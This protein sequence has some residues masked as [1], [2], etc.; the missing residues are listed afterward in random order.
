MSAVV[1][2][3]VRR[4]T[5]PAVAASLMKEELCLALAAVAQ[6]R[7]SLSTATGG[8]TSASPLSTETLARRSLRLLPRCT[9]QEVRMIANGAHAL[10]WFSSPSLLVTEA[11]ARTLYRHTVNAG[12]SAI[13]AKSAA[14]HKVR[15]GD[16]LAVV[17]LASEAQRYFDA[18][19]FLLATQ[20]AV[21]VGAQST[22]MSAA[23]A[24]EFV[25]VICGYAGEADGAA[26]VERLAALL[27][28]SPTFASNSPGLAVLKACMRDRP[29]KVADK[30]AVSY[31]RWAQRRRS[32]LEHVRTTGDAAAPTDAA[33]GVARTPIQLLK[34]RYDAWQVVLALLAEEEEVSDHRLQRA[35]EAAGVCHIQDP[36]TLSTLDRTVALRVASS[37]LPNAVLISYE[38]RVYAQ[39]HYYPQALAALKQRDADT[40]SAVA[41]ASAV[42]S[43][44]SQPTAEALQRV[45]VIRRVYKDT[46][47]G[48]V[49][50]EKDLFQITT[51]ID[52]SSADEVAM[53]ACVFAR[54]KEVPTS[55]LILLPRQLMSLTVEGVVALV[56]A[57]RHDRRGALS[58]VLQECLRTSAHLQECILSAPTELLVELAEALSRPVSRWTS[59]SDEM[60][61]L[62]EQVVDMVIA[63]VLPQAEQMPLSTLLLVMTIGGFHLAR[64]DDLVQAVCNRLADHL[65]AAVTPPSII[66][67]VE[68][69]A[70]LHSG[71]S[72]QE[73]LLDVL[74]DATAAH[75]SPL[76]ESTISADASCLAGLVRFATTQ[77][78]YG[79]P[80]MAAVG[81][82]L[83]QRVRQG[84]W[85]ALP[86]EML[87][88]AALFALDS[89]ALISSTA[90]LELPHA[91]VVH[92]VEAQRLPSMMTVDLAIALVQLMELMPT[93]DAENAQAL[94]SHV[95]RVA[96]GLSPVEVARLLALRHRSSTAAAT[97]SVEVE[98]VHY[99]TVSRHV[100]ALPPDTFTSL[101]LVA[102]QPAFDTVLAN[103]LVD[104]LP[105][106]AD[107]LSAHQ[108]SQCVF[109]LG[110]M[111]DAGQRLSH[112]VMTE[113]LSDYVVDNIE[114]F[115]SGR[116]IAALLHGF[117]KLQCTKRNLYSVFS[118]Q[119]LRR[120]IIATLE[121]R[122]ISLLFFAFGSARFVNKDLM[123]IL[124]RTFVVHVDSLAAP[125]VLMSLRGLSRMNLLN[126]TFYRKVGRRA[127]EL[128]DE[129]PLQAQC[130][131][132]HAYGAVEEAHPKLAATLSKRI[133]AAVESLPSVSVAT[134]V[135]TSLWLMGAD[136]VMDEDIRTIIDY[137]VQHASQL[138]GPDIM[139][140][141][142]IALNQ[143][144]KQPQLLHGM[145]ARAIELQEKQQLEPTA[146]RAVLDTLS[147]QLVFHH[148]ARVHLSQLARTVSKEMV[149]LSGEE[150][151]QL[152]LITS[153]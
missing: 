122:S 10:E 144:W 56:R 101:C 81:T 96:S 44:S 108:L 139:K 141:C 152:N 60:R 70:A 3:L 20:H 135:L 49:V 84:G 38:N 125:D 23:V 39:A 30:W 8:G 29:L 74:G 137:V 61:A 112:Q 22:S 55:L 153:H 106:M 17:Q 138:T 110:E 100:L 41:G 128:I 86:P 25:A 133:A 115:T 47:A 126:A 37:T 46:V 140:L 91:V 40:S 15:L 99:S 73:R 19:I 68:V 4:L 107:S 123:D 6:L 88:A 143:N 58:T 151:E 63:H 145:A 11:L 124:S 146:A 119:L 111:A 121:F 64:T 36:V 150:Q 59:P 98:A 116:D 102:A 134:D 27:E 7:P 32:I 80:E 120:P 53:A 31:A 82:G 90:S 43:F 92:L 114:L 94:V 95:L 75:F 113:A 130:D 71:D 132:L 103:L 28:A 33:E 89:S 136:M 83:V 5:V 109:G 117:A 78:K 79:S 142:S 51:V 12:Q 77:V 52:M 26:A 76:L 85:D 62:E 72:R 67:C 105:L 93:V 34:A 148:A 104:M 57:S 13:E 9:P 21:K 14:T 87:V 42:A 35:L 2:Q 127:I 24:E 149:L 54:V 18:T 65:V 45:P 48:A 118:T 16:I 131:L 97:P 50:A 147:S 66:L 129:F 1:T 69:L